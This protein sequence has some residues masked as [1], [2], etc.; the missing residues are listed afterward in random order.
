MLSKARSQY[1]LGN[2]PGKLLE[3]AV[4]TLKCV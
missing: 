2:C 4:G 3:R 1:T